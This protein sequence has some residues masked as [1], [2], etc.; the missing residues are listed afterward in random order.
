MVYV[1]NMPAIAS[2]FVHDMPCPNDFVFRLVDEDCGVHI[3]D[4]GLARCE[5]R[6]LLSQDIVTRWYRPPEV[7][8]CKREYNN[9]VD[10][11]S[12]GCIFAE[13][14][15]NPSP[16]R[17]GLFPGHT[18]K[19]QTDKIIHVTA[20]RIIICMLV[21]TRML[22]RSEINFVLKTL[23]RFADDGVAV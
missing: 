13:L 16:N 8:L 20:A 21:Y 3:C 23:N 4:F 19:D 17:S 11:W 18:Y 22:R 6:K 10:I 5:S 2:C 12:A 14:I 7:L 15:M 9:A 1:R